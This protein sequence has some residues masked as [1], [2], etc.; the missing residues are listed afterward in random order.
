M[1]KYT[2]RFRKVNKRI[3]NHDVFGFSLNSKRF[4]EFE[5][6][7]NIVILILLFDKHYRSKILIIFM[8]NLEK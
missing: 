2:L 1:N 5:L 4:D 6:T 8:E 7:Y 3:N